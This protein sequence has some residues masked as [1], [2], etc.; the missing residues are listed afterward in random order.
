MGRPRGDVDGSGMSRF[1]AF[2]VLFFC[3]LL[4]PAA[5]QAATPAFPAPDCPAQLRAGAALT[6][7]LLSDATHTVKRYTAGGDTRGAEVNCNYY[8][9]S[10]NYNYGW[11]VYYLFRTDT[12]AQVAAAL[13][14]GYGPLGGWA[15]QSVPY[16]GVSTTVYAYVVCSPASD[17]DTLAGAKAML[18]A[19]TDMAAPQKAAPTNI[20]KPVSA[21]KAKVTKIDG[22]V[23]VS[24]DGGKTF[25]KLAPGIALRDGDFVSTGFESSA[26]LDFGYD[27]LTV[28]SMTQ[29]RIDKYTNA[30]KIAKTKVFLKIGSLHVFERHTNAIRSDFSV[31][32]PICSAS[33]RDTDTVVSAAKDGTVR[34]FTVK[35]V[36]Y[37]KGLA[38][39]RT[40]T[41]PAGYMTT[42]GPDKKAS[43]PVRTT[44]AA[45]KAAT[46]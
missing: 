44:P 14:E 24:T 32:T 10:N 31:T 20:V 18:A 9:S 3:G 30:D 22:D 2:L 26:V 27:S 1:P 4:V 40:I 8:Q 42:V 16:C 33:V 28:G 5:A 34:V 43:K 12:P 25:T 37:V 13:A 23:E 36:S 38:D 11:T 19:A 35:D 7:S 21:V 41:V 17:A 29:F 45:L 6:P 39:A 46:G 15:H